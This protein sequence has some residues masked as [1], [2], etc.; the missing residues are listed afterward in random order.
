MA[1]L[2]LIA[3]ASTATARPAAMSRRT[4]R[5]ASVGAMTRNRRLN[6]T[7]A[8]TVFGVRPSELRVSV[9]VSVVALASVAC[10]PVVTLAP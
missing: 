1:P 2:P 8:E 3:A 5:S 10:H 4:V 6:S 9:A 7:F